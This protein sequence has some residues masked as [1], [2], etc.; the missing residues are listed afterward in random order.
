MSIV[1]FNSSTI[2][3]SAPLFFTLSFF[4][5]PCVVGEQAREIELC[6]FINE[7]WV[8]D[9]ILALLIHHVD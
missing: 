9:H 1:T 2:F 7:C 3:V 5:S 6:G 4:G 8:D